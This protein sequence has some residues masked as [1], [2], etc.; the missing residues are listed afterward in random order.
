MDNLNDLKKLWLTANTDSLPDSKEMVNTIKKYRNKKII[1]KAALITAAALLAGFMVLVAFMY[2]STMLTTRIGE[3]FFI[4]SCIILI[5]TNTNSLKRMYRLKNCTNKEFVQ[6]LEQA[7]QNRI[8]YYKKTQVAGLLFNSAGLLLYMYEL[9]YGNLILCV[10]AY[11]VMI[12]YLLI[13]WL[14]VRPRVYKRQSKKFIE[15]IQRMKL[16]SN[17]F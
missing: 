13:I 12:I 14:V 16:L 8:F 17:Q 2:H 10:V 5:V 9:V 3:A 7:T 15:K 6:H 1:N 4:I 11:T